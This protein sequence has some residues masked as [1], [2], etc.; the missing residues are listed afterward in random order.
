MAAS[1]DTTVVQGDTLKWAMYLTDKGG[2]AYNLAGCTLSM[3]IRKSYYPATLVSTISTYVPAG[4]VGTDFSDGIAG[5][6]SGD[7]TGGT[8]YV[9]IGATYTS[10]FPTDTTAKY[11]LQII[12]PTGNTVTT[13]LRGSLTILPE[14]TRL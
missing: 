6:L 12:N 5:G 11:D 13:I 7:A 10:K 9:C 3:Q 8:I 1:F 4:T 2:T 14:V